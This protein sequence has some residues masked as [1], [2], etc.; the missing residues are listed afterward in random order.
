M[1]ET[2]QSDASYASSL[3]ALE[4]ALHGWEEVEQTL[5]PAAQ[6]GLEVPN[7]HER[8]QGAQIGLAAALDKAN[9]ALIAATDEE[10]KDETFGQAMEFFGRSMAMLNNIIAGIHFGRAQ[11]MGR[12][13]I[14]EYTLRSAYHLQAKAMER[15]QALRQAAEQ[16][17]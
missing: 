16:A 13:D 12:S 11:L 15:A 5:I 17:G 10:K 1:S 7:L 14:F 4:K 8:I 2:T 6:K 3:D 9:Q